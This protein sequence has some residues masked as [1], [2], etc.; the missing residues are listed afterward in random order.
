MPGE[1][2]RIVIA[3]RQAGTAAAFSPVIRALV[4]DGYQPVVLAYPPAQMVFER[5]AVPAS[6]ISSADDAIP[7]LESFQPPAV[8]L[9][10]TS[11]EV[12]DDFRVWDIA[13]SRGITTI[14]FVDQWV[15]YR[16]RFSTSMSSPFDA[17]PHEI[18]V[19]DE[20]AARRLIEAGAPDDRLIVLG[21]PSLEAMAAHRST[22]RGEIRQRHLEGRQLLLV[23]A[24]EPHS[25]NGLASRLGF[26]EHDALGMAVSV[27]NSVLDERDETGVLVIRPHPSEESTKF[28]RY[29]RNERQ[30]LTV[31]VDAADHPGEVCAAADLVVGMTSMF[32]LVAHVMRRPVVSLQPRRRQSSDLIDGH[33]IPV[34]SDLVAG[35][36]LVQRLLSGPLPEPPAFLRRATKR[37]VAHLVERAA[38]PRTV[39]F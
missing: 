18:A 24:S 4:G 33:Q 11:L 2:P 9:T 28:G 38:I 13:A 3:A 30:R 15:N 23:F 14:A 19:V 29:I 1:G 6:R 36:A 27:L 34:A 17:L 5:E 7:L 21:S 10:G 39:S 20:L 35:R 12:A 32:L 26:T 8:L 25:T 37:F 22:H 16:E 31:R